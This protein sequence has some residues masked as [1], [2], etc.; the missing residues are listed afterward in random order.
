M[1]NLPYSSILRWYTG[2]ALATVDSFVLPTLA[3]AEQRGYWLPN[4]SRKL[5]AAVT[6][7]AV[8]QKIA[9]HANEFYRALAD[10]HSVVDDCAFD[11]RRSLT[12]AWFK[13][14]MGMQYGSNNVVHMMGAIKQ[15]EEQGLPT[16]EQKEVLAQARTFA[17]DFAP[18]YTLIV[19]LDATRPKPVFTALGLSPTVTATLTEQ[20]K[21]NVATL[22]FPEMEEKWIERKDEKG[23][24][25]RIPILVIKWPENTQH[26]CSRFAKGNQCHACGHA[27]RNGFNWVPFLIDDAKGVPHSCWVGRDCA[28]NI[29]NVDVKGDAEYAEGSGAPSSEVTKGR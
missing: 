8:A 3:A 16:A 2:K 17:A 26:N 25:K 29:F 19:K 28:R 7:H 12:D 1:T 5:R 27:I 21:L 18:I 10:D 20:L 15:I 14:N 11:T 6:K 24:V 4:E 23:V 22:R 9:R 13:I